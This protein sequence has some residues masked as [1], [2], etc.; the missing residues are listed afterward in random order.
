MRSGIF[1]MPKLLSKLQ[2]GTVEQTIISLLTL[3]PNCETP[4]EVHKNKDSFHVECP[5]CGV[6]GYRYETERLAVRDFRNHY[7]IPKQ[8]GRAT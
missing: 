3:C 1:Q 4:S 2:T 7:G 6:M 8:S 5:T